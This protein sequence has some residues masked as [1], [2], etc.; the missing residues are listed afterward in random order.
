MDGADQIKRL[1]LGC[2][3][4][5]SWM[6]QI[7][8]RG[9]LSVVYVGCHGSSRSDQEANSRLFTLGVMDGADQIK[10]LTLG[11]FVRTQSCPIAIYI[12]CG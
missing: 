3:R 12:I 4:W 5:V 9:S 7:R 1:T 2:L 10:R 8:S 11:C 6:E